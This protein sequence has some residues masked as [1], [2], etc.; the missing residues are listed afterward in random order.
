MCWFNHNR[1]R[2]SSFNNS[3]SD[4]KAQFHNIK[5]YKLIE[6]HLLHA[7]FS[8]TFFMFS[9]YC[10]LL[11]VELVLSLRWNIEVARIKINQMKFIMIQSKRKQHFIST[12]EF[13]LS[14]RRVTNKYKRT[15]WFATFDAALC[16]L[17]GAV[18][19]CFVLSSFPN[20]SKFV[21]ANC[22]SN[23]AFWGRFWL[24][25]LVFF[26]AKTNAF[27]SAS[28]LSCWAALCCPLDYYVG[29]SPH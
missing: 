27:W 22:L 29:W 14:E 13:C 4:N 3:V 15:S 18:A 20:S 5:S 21:A 10:S 11:I 12:T 25:W 26:N 19:F 24:I 23:G 6:T 2:M 8:Y 28:S 1:R 9:W 7:F 16:C 17:V